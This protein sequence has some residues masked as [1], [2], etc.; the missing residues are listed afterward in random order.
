M[1]NDTLM[2][3]GRPMWAWENELKMLRQESVEVK[4]MAHDAYMKMKLC[5]I[6]EIIQNRFSYSGDIYL[7]ITEHRQRAMHHPSFTLDQLEKIIEWK[8]V[9][10]GALK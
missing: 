1:S 4:K 10:P 3:D 8:P 7:R 6:K 9:N 2:P 5:H